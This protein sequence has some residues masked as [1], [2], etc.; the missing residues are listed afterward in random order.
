MKKKSFTLIE[1]LVVLAIIS[2][3]MAILL[4]ALR[5]AREMATGVSCVN[6][7]KQL[8]VGVSSYAGD[9]NDYLPSPVRDG[10]SGRNWV[11]VMYET[12]C[13]LVKS[14]QGI[15]ACPDAQGALAGWDQISGNGTAADYSMNYH[16]GGVNPWDV[17]AYAGKLTAHKSDYVLLLDAGVG[18][19]FSSA[20][21]DYVKYRHLKAA[22][23]LFCDLGVRR[24][25]I[26]SP[27]DIKYGVD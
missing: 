3:L 26:L 5:K 17:S 2:V 22:N 24:H 13:V 10:W 15:L 16:L 4:P 25:S 19:C 18:C 8:G 23:I 21:L 14:R 11:S 27:D 9:Y 20:S 6:N 7:L 12:H 1:M